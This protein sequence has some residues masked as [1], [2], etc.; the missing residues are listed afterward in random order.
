MRKL[1]LGIFCWCLGA[2][3][4]DASAHHGFSAHFDPDKLIRIEGTV[5]RFDF[6]NPHG[7]LFIET[8]SDAGETVV[9]DCELQARSQLLRHG[10]DETL[11]TVGETIVVM[12][13]EARRDPLRCEF[14]V[15]YF[16]DGSSFEMRTVDKARSQFADNTAASIPADNERTILGV[17]IRPGMYGDESGRGPRT[18]GD[19]ITEAGKA[20][21]AAYNPVTENPVIR[22]EPGSPVRTWGPP[23]LATKISREDGKVIIYHES[24]DV[25][26]TVHLDITAHP[27]DLLPSDMGHSFGHFEDDALIIETAVFAQGVLVGPTLHTDQMTMRERLSIR[28]D[29]GRLLIEWTM[30]DPHYYSEPLTGSQELHS[31]NQEIIRYDCTPESAL[32]YE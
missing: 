32:A 18:G 14:A 20:A 6:I 23:G 10:A 3:A 31:T 29:T 16:A 9:Y 7:H 22:C 28:E 2:F 17:W 15:G 13:F 25:T 11:F 27:T 8:I 4:P 21:A 1:A 24:M 12:G 5:K 26:R 30:L 19:S